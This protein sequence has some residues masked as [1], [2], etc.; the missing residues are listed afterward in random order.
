MADFISFSENGN[1]N[2]NGN[3]NGELLHHFLDGQ[4]LNFGFG[5]GHPMEN[6]FSMQRHID[7]NQLL[8]PT[9]QT[10]HDSVFSISS[11]T[12]PISVISPHPHQAAL[13]PYIPT[14]HMTPH[15]Y[16]PRPVSMRRT[17]SQLSST[18]FNHRQQQP[19]H[20]HRAS[21]SKVP[22]SGA[23]HMSRSPTHYTAPPLP[24]QHYQ[25]APQ[26]CATEAPIDYGNFYFPS[27]TD[28]SPMSASGTTPYYSLN[29]D[30]R[31]STFVSGSGNSRPVK[32]MEKRTFSKPPPTR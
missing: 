12:S 20:Q 28:T 26:P 1:G 27:Q 23:L 21:C 9:T 13:Q 16:S 25:T 10:R 11:A 7:Q 31:S 8:S 22:Q 2:D 5:N 30:D 14:A 15:G 29:G 32:Y 19:I 24:Q 17:E 18:S 6:D 3:G 4:S